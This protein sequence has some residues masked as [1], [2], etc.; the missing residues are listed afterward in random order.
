MSAYF[1]AVYHSIIAANLPA[2]E[3]TICRAQLVTLHAT[4]KFAI[5]S[6]E[7]NSFYSAYH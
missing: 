3:S 1:S 4:D 6:T 7:C 5:F 2:I